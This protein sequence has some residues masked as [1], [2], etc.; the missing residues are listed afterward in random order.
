MGCDA[1]W[2]QQVPLKRRQNSTGLYGATKTAIFISTVDLCSGDTLMVTH[3]TL[4]C[5]RL[6][7]QR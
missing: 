1:V 2:R 5:L 4:V 6:K 7:V 3:S